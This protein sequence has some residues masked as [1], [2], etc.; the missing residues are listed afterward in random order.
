MNTQSLY[1]PCDIMLL[2]VSFLHSKGSGLFTHGVFT[3]Q[4]MSLEN[5]EKN[6]DCWIIPTN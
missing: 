2:L 3:I 5:S 1:C 4:H 6:L